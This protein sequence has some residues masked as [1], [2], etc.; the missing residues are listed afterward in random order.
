M[1]LPSQ[2]LSP[3]KV[4]PPTRHYHQC[5]YFEEIS[6]ATGPSRILICNQING[7]ANGRVPDEVAGV[8]RKLMS[9]D[10]E[11]IA[12]KVLHDREWSME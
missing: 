8:I 9:E 4:V 7:R 10:G 1:T 3:L 6:Q 2:L 12:G 11:V 5:F